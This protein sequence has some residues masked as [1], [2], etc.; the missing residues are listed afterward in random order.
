MF[1]N[2]D[3]RITLELKYPWEIRAEPIKAV[4]IRPIIFMAN[5]WMEFTDFLLNK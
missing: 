3:L 5:L 1:G 4:F 2:M